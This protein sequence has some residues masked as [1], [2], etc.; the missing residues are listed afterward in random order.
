MLISATQSSCFC[1]SWM[2]NESLKDFW[3]LDSRILN[4]SSRTSIVP[5]KG[6]RSYE[7][8]KNCTYCIKVR[9]FFS[10][11]DPT[12]FSIKIKLSMSLDSL[13]MLHVALPL[14]DVS[15]ISFK[16]YH[17]WITRNSWKRYW[18]VFFFRK[19]DFFWRF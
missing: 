10:S 16:F 15:N 14:Q 17:L 8:I 13:N 1:V 18:N 4:I 5:T 3:Q 19:W 9:I 7:V 6:F 12:K 11:K 2:L